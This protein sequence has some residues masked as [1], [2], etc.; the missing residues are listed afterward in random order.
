MRLES[1]SDSVEIKFVGVALTMNLSHNIF[2]I[3]VAKRTAEFVIVHVR[4]AFPLPPAP[5]HLI[6]V[7]HLELP[8]GALPGDA[9][10]VGAVG[11]ELQQE[12]P[13]LYLPTPC[14]GKRN[15]NVRTSD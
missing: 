4:L 9:V 7:C 15:R 14:G 2:I 11:E 10:G 13:Q 6:G 3:V 12:L 5:S 8:V 1:L